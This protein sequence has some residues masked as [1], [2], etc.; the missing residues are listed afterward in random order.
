MQW[1]PTSDELD[2]DPNFGATPVIVTLGVIEN[3]S[4][5]TAWGGSNRHRITAFIKAGTLSTTGMTIGFQSHANVN[6]T[7]TIKAD[8]HWQVYG[9]PTSGE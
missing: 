1:S 6:S 9:V 2:G 3:T 4:T 5:A 8:V 7:N